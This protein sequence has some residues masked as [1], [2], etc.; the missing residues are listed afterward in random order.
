MSEFWKWLDEAYADGSQGEQPK[1]TKYNMEVA[2]AAGRAARTAPADQV[3]PVAEMKGSYLYP[4][5]SIPSGAKLYTA[6]DALQAEVERL[7]EEVER[8]NEER[9]E[10][11]NQVDN[12]QKLISTF[13]D[14][15]FRTETERDE[16]KAEAEETLRASQ[17]LWREVERLQ[18]ENQSLLMQCTGMGNSIDEL[19]RSLQNEVNRRNQYAMESGELDR[20]VEALTN[21]N[22]ACEDCF[23]EMRA[24]RDAL[25]AD[26]ER[27]RWLRNNGE[28][29]RGV[30][31]L[32]VTG[33]EKPATAWA[34]TFPDPETLDACIDDEIARTAKPEVKS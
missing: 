12:D 3:E 6:P 2:Y 8:L 20:Q 30:M 28:T 13:A 31:V 24:E 15:Q 18:S 23:I 7:R 25:R 10:L 21:S 32:C 26:A 5:K 11:M 33:W 9:Q 22:K 17:L 16:L 19:K 29:E 1:F 14:T 34:T 27:Y 4:L